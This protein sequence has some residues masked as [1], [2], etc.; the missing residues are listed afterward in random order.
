MDLGYPTL[1]DWYILF[2]VKF[3]QFLGQWYLF[4]LSWSFSSGSPSFI[5]VL[6]MLASSLS[7]FG[8]VPSFCISWF[9][10]LSTLLFPSLEVVVDLPNN[11]PT[12]TSTSILICP[13]SF[14]SSCFSFAG[15][16]SL[17]TEFRSSS[18]CCSS[19][20]ETRN[21]LWMNWKTLKWH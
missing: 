11:C 8:P 5:S 13:F 6:I 14:S 2:L 12:D 7:M 17:W 21:R 10:L 9:K 3:S 20:T 16:S 19:S 18:S 1:P 4:I 15:G